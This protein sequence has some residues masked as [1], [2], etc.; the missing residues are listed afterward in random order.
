MPFGATVAGDVFFKESL[1]SA[2]AS[3]NRFLS[4][5]MTSWLLGTSQTTVIMTKHL[6]V[7]YKPAQKCN[8]KL[9][10]DKLQYKQN[11]VYFFCETYTTSGHK[12]ARSKVS[13]ITAMPWS[14]NKK[15]IQSFI[16]MIK[17]LSKF[18]PRLSEL[19][20]LI[21]ELSKYKV[22]FNW[23]PEHQAAFLQ[24]KKEISCAPVLAYYNPKKQTVLQ[25]D[26]NIKGLGA[27]LP[28]RRESLSILQGK[29]LTEAWSPERI[30]VH[31]DRI[32]C[33]GLGNGEIPPLF[34]CQSF[35]S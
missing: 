25:T 22:P 7:C 4:L 2:L 10:F 33:S 6:L 32:T 23:G 26:A 24:M 27:C 18:L 13:A 3:W 1:M 35:P 31:R 29:A 5:Q 21:R 19:A 14:T 11:E 8:V 34:L 15:Q 16:G 17:Y 30:C 12:P 20:E 9:D 28:S